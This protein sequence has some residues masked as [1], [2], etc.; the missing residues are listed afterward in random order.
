MLKSI[1]RMCVCVVTLEV[2][3]LPVA[4]AAA[5]A[6]TRP[7][8]VVRTAPQSTSGTNAYLR[9]L[10]L[11]KKVTV[12]FVF[13]SEDEKSLANMAFYKRLG[14][15]PL[16]DKVN[17]RLI[18]LTRQGVAPAIEALKAAGVKLNSAGSYPEDPAG[19]PVAIGSV[20][21]LDPDGAVVKAWTGFPATRQQDE[22]IKFLETTVK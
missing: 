6:R 8:A 1:G 12:L 4:D 10:G 5:S 2:V 17:G 21:V 18:V 15:L 22:I 7:A 9:R 14:L 3:A 19:L 20:V 13:S 11:G 16:F